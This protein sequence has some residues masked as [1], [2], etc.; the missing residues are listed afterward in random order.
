MALLHRKCTLIFLTRPF[1]EKAKRKDD[2]SQQEV[3]QLAWE[4]LV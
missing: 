4:G 2:C 3:L 1:V